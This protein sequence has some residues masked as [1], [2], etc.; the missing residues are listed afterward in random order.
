MKFF[1]LLVI[2]ISLFAGKPDLFLLNKYSDDINV[3]GWYMSEKLD[4][5]RAYWDGKKL[6]SRSGKVLRTPNFFI[7]DFPKY[8]LDGELWSKREDFS[9]IVSIV[10]KKNPHAKWS[11]LTYNIFEVPHA[12]GNLLQRLKRVKE[13][14]YIKV[15]KQ[16]KVKD[17]KHLKEFQESVESKGGE[18]VVVRDGSL[19]YYTGRNNNALKVKSFI[20]EECEVVG[21]NEGRGKYEGMIGSLSCRLK[22]LKVIKIGSG[23]ND[24]QRAMPPKIGAIITF[25]YYGLTTKGNPRFPIFLR[26]RE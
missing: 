26:V 23:L 17:K 4:G 21:Y 14:R 3:T 12:K 2:S 6:I 15:I 11:K 13:T 24:Y 9:N 20:D 19:L 22:N 5:I 25:K 16:I 7:K 1:I 8:E 10:N 18:G